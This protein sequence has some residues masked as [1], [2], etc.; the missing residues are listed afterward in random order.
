MFS[1]YYRIKATKQVAEWV[2]ATSQFG[3]FALKFPDGCILEFEHWEIE[4]IT[5]EQYL[6][7]QKQDL[8]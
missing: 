5:H 1:T 3:T 8:N 4:E 7:A 2:A 6:D